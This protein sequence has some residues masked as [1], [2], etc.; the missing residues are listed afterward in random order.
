MQPRI[1]LR[2][3]TVTRPTAGMK[4]AMLEAPLGDDV[5][6]DDPTV[7]L[8]EERAAAVLGKQ[9]A[10]FVPSGTMANQIAIRCHTEPGD[11]IICHRDSHIIHYETGAPAVIS[12]CMIA[13]AEGEAGLFDE[14]ELERLVR[15]DNIHAAR[16]R[17]LVIENTHNRGGGTVWP[18]AQTARLTARGRALGLRTHLDGARIWNASVASGLAPARLAQHFDSVSACFS[19]GLGAPVGSVVAGDEAFIAKARRVRKM[20]GGAMRQS[21]VL[22]AAALYALEHHVQRLA[23]D[24]AAAARLARSLASIDGLSVDPARVQTNIVYVD[25]GAGLGPAAAYC[26][27]VAAQGVLVL[28]T[29][30]ARFRAVTHLDVTGAMIDDAAGAFAAAARV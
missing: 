29:G 28:P 30:P 11:E 21:G 23:E 16:S 20:L 10:C 2:S 26:Q 12:G 17:L 3:D 4:R 1:D 15:P 27:R 22:A 25:V 14:Q 7:A 18:E 19:K 13:P 24:H 6:G 8:L 5:L 9:R